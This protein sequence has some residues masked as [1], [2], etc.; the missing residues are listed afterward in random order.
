M[1]AILESH[2]GENR[3]NIGLKEMSDKRKVYFI[4][5]ENRT[6][7]GLKDGF[8]LDNFLKDIREN[9]TN[10]GLKVE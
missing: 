4:H 9:R 3:T 10:I 8:D 7:I 2:T 5:G 6:N 1:N